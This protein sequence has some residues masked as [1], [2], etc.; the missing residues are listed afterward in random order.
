M[1]TTTRERAAT[2][3][4][5]SSSSSSSSSSARA[6]LEHLVRALNQLGVGLGAAPSA[7]GGGRSE[8]ARGRP[9]RTSSSKSDRTRGAL[10][11]ELLRRAKFGHASA[12]SALWRAL[13]DLA[14]V[15]V[16]G[17][18]DPEVAARAIARARCDGKDGGEASSSDLRGDGDGEDA[19]D[20]R[21][22]AKEDLECATLARVYLRAHA[23]PHVD[24][25]DDVEPV[26]EM[27]DAALAKKKKKK[28]KKT[29]TLANRDA[30]S[31]KGSRALL[32]ALAWLTRTLDVFARAHAD[33]A[34]QTL[35]LS[36]PSPRTPLPPYPSSDAARAEAAA[37]AA[38]EEEV[39]ETSSQTASHTTAFAW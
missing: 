27:T 35:R 39:R 15:A 29:R 28:K 1:P 4:A 19:R 8:D 20:A 2:A 23:Y 26:A 12:T 5:A 36:P 11:S 13:H 37:I 6:C 30:E 38:E 21:R 31:D 34:A 25:L 17:F 14:L 22:E 16:A 18:P 3:A 32:F 33:A 9:S 10:T 7:G 24:E